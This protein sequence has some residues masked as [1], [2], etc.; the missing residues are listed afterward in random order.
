MAGNGQQQFKVGY[1]NV[2]MTIL[3]LVLLMK[4]S[5]HQ[6]DWLRMEKI[7]EDGG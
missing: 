4:L 3:I 1:G 7:T 2:V 5:I 6:I